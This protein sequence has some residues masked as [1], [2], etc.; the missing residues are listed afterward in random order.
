MGKSDDHGFYHG[1]GRS[2]PA[3]KFP[4]GRGSRP[5]FFAGLCFFH[6]HYTTFCGF[7]NMQ[8]NTF[9]G[10][11]DIIR[12]ALRRRKDGR[13]GDRRKKAGRCP[14]L[15][16]PFLFLAFALPIGRLAVFR[17]REVCIAGSLSPERSDVGHVL[18]FPF[19]ALRDLT[20][21]R[22]KPAR[23][24]RLS[25]TPEVPFPSILSPIKDFSFVFSQRMHDC[26]YL[27]SDVS[28]RHP[29]YDEAYGTAGKA[30]TAQVQHNLCYRV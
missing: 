7:F 13:M 24:Q 19:R 14:R 16:L 27:F 3:H 23:E 4:G 30:N 26:F 2:F 8:N 1:F 21:V 22:I 17:R 6:V 15:L 11:Y 28:R 29:L 10:G 18:V 25:C 20:A 12:R 9:F 5:A